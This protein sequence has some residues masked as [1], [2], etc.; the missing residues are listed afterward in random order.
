VLFIIF[1]LFFKIIFFSLISCHEK[2]LNSGQ[3]DRSRAEPF[4]TVFLRV[5][6]MSSSLLLLLLL[7]LNVHITITTSYLIHVFANREKKLVLYFFSIPGFFKTFILP[8]MN[9][10]KKF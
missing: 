2:T 6:V 5:S 8:K 10:Q 7:L 1:C 3:K 4:L 9:T